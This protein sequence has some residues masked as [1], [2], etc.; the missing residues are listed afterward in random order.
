MKTV[1]F[2]LPDAVVAAIEKEARARRVSKSA[3]VRD[4]LG[5]ETGE[6][7]WTTSLEGI[8]DLIGSVDGLPTDLSSRRKAALKATGYGRKRPR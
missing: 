8:A 1:S 5:R 4:R 3:V 6:H 7:R 2:R